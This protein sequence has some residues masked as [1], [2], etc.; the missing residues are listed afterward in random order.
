MIKG[1]HTASN[2]ELSADEQMVPMICGWWRED[3]L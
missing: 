3:G 2:T 1:F